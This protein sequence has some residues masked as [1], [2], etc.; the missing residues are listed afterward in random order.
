MQ[1]INTILVELGDM[2]PEQAFTDDRPEV[3]GLARFIRQMVERK[4]Q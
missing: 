1:H 3:R 4:E 2:T